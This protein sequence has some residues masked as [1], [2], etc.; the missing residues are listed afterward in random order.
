MQRDHHH[1]SPV[2]A[3]CILRVAS[4]S[5][6]T[7]RVH[8][9]ILEA[10]PVCNVFA[11][12]AVIHLHAVDPSQR[13]GLR[14]S[15]VHLTSS[16]VVAMYIRWWSNPLVAKYSAPGN[17]AAVATDAGTGTD[18]YDSPGTDLSSI[19]T[20]RRDMIRDTSDKRKLLRP[21]RL[22]SK[23]RETPRQPPGRCH[24]NGAHAKHSKQQC[25]KL[26]PAESLETERKKCWVSYA[27]YN[28]RA[29]PVPMS[30]PRIS[31]IVIVLLLLLVIRRLGR[32]RYGR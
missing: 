17:K 23:P 25:Q 6:S 26:W 3:R 24:P 19:S 4:L 5:I 9:T 28:T 22:H 8:G 1:R 2:R 30:T 11:G 21:L 31:P 7:W 10:Y 32:L 18:A 12:P 15:G 16:E 20:R 14:R 27:E 29:L 13:A